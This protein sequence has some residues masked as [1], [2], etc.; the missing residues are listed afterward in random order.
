VC[1]GARVPAVTGVDGGVG[2]AKYALALRQAGP[3]PG[4]PETIEWASRRLIYSTGQGGKA[5]LN[6]SMCDQLLIGP[7]VTQTGG[8]GDDTP[9]CRA[10]KATL[11]AGAAKVSTPWSWPSALISLTPLG[12][13]SGRLYVSSRSDNSFMIKST[14]ASDTCDVAWVILPGA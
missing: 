6:H 9:N 2:A 1:I 5:I 3:A 7:T 13:P 14:S 12:S 10:G 4:R 8:Y 11:V